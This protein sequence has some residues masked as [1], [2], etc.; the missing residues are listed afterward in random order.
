M[1]STTT[2]LRV[3]KI[4]SHLLLGARSLCGLRGET[5]VRR[6]RLRWAL[7]LRQ[8]ID[9]A[10]Y[11]GVYESDTLAFLAQ[12]VR[13]G[14]VA[15]DIGAN[16]GA[17]TLPLARLVGAQGQVH[18]FEPTAYAYQKLLTN[19]ALNVEL[20]TRVSA[21]QTMLLESAEAVLDEALYASWPLSSVDAALHPLHRGALMSLRGATGCSLDDYLA[22]RAIRRVDLIKLDVDGNELR[23]LRGARTTLQRCRPVLVFELAPY[24]LDERPGTLEDILALLKHSGY[25]LADLV[26]KRSLPSD[27]NALRAWIPHGCGLNIIGE[28]S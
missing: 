14:S 16:V 3:A 2:K 6:Q 13:L 5:T 17:L 26:S 23:V 8:G 22:D 28:P 25:R 1:L 20:T 10:I 19:L 7:D 4:A 9:L 21:Q 11:L 15:I 24:I 27:A 18:A 12:R